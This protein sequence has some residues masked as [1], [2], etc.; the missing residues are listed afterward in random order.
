M[1]HLRNDFL[2][3]NKRHEFHLEYSDNIIPN[4][5]KYIMLLFCFIL[6][7]FLF[8]FVFVCLSTMFALLKNIRKI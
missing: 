3:H 5:D 2:L 8:C 7:W 4:Y 1:L 6:I